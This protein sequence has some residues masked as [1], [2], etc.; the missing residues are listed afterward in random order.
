MGGRVENRTYTINVQQTAE[1]GFGFHVPEETGCIVILLQS[2]VIDAAGTEWKL[3]TS[4]TWPTK[5]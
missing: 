4:S 5:R 3:S 2:R 1:K